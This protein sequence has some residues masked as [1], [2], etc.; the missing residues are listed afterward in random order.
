MKRALVLA[1]MSIGWVTAAVAQ[2]PYTSPSPGPHDP[3]PPMNAPDLR[4]PPPCAPA[5]NLASTG[6]IMS[7]ATATPT[8]SG[9]VTPVDSSGNLKCSAN[10]QSATLP[11]LAP[12]VQ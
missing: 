9:G 2:S 5:P 3:N 10:T 12:G 11:G 1:M 7:P 4:L 8:T 6:G